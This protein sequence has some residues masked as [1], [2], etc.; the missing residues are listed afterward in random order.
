VSRRWVAA[1]HLQLLDRYL[2][3]VAAGRIT[4]LLV[5]AP[6][7]HGKSELCS[8]YMP[9]WFLGRYPNRRVILCSY[10]FEFAASWGRKARDVLSAFGQELFGVTIRPDAAAAHRFDIA[11][12]EGGMVCAGAGGPITGRG[13]D[14]LLVDDP[15]K[16]HEDT[17][18]LARRDAMWDWWRSVALT[19][20]EPG[21]RVC[22]VMTR[23]HEDDLA[24]RIL[25]DPDVAK[26]WTV[27]N[28]PAIAEDDDVLGRETGQALWPARFDRAALDAARRQLGETL[29]QSLYQGRPRPVEG[30]VFHADRFRYFTPVEGGYDLGSSIVTQQ[31]CWRFM[32]VDPAISTKTSAD[33]TV[34]GVF[35]VSESN[36]LIVVDIQRQ[37]LEGPDQIK[38]LRSMFEQY[39]PRFIAVESTAYQ[40]ALLQ[41]LKR[42][43][44]PVRELK[45]D[46]DKLGRALHAAARVDGGDVYFPTRAPWL[47]SFEEELV[48][49]PQ[50][51][52]DDQ[53]DVLSY[54][55]QQVLR[56]RYG[57]RPRVR[58]A[59]IDPPARGEIIGGF[60]LDGSYWLDCPARW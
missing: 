23:W 22:L 31:S 56:G 57:R 11:G 1:K 36:Q 7:R 17:A 60:W 42:Q 35:D 16:N 46:R 8:Q 40:L 20:L 6:P 55:A 37:R 39:G 33:Y 49:F 30:S 19:R 5:T 44:F 52:Y 10:E 13:A 24:G 45:A 43:G 29:F 15:V 27:V 50:A 3:E 51:R 9:A 53:V 25:S 28:L 48:S 34:V 14:L 41:A 58:I 12:W 18:S 4:R 54:A 2:V 47:G 21:G 32:T 59:H 38:L 26:L